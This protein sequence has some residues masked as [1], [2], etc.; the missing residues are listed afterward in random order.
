VSERVQLVVP[1]PPRP[2]ER[3]R[4]GRRGHWYT[5]ADTEDYEQRV[6][7]AWRQARAPGF[8]SLPL[9]VSAHFYVERPPS[10]YGTGRNSHRVK[11]GH[12]DLI[13]PGDLDNY[14]KGLLDGLQK[15]RAFHNDRQIIC[16]AGVHKSWAARGEGRTTIDVWVACRH[17][18]D[19]AA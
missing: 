6:A 3:A 4:R 2:C 5:P 15:A 17:P 14:L 1:G 16:L 12:A 13:P 9:A 18:V 10:H 19:L 11:A 8:G 7:W